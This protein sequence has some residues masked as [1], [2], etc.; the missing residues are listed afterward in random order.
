M[1]AAKQQR[2]RETLLRIEAVALRLFSEQDVRGV[3]VR[4]IVSAA[5]TSTGSF[6][7]RFAS[8]D[9]LVVFLSERVAERGLERWREGLEELSQDLEGSLREATGALA[10]LIVRSLKEERAARTVL[11][12]PG[13]GSDSPWSGRWKEL[14]RRRREDTRRL[15]LAHRA[16]VHHPS[17]ELAASLVYGLAY[18]AAAGMIGEDPVEDTAGLTTERVVDEVARVVH[19]YLGVPH[20][21]VVTQ[22]VALR[23]VD[24]FDVWG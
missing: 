7:A 11:L 9:E 6:Y 13:R 2:S 14:T 16:D 8:K 23:P 24:P 15:I 21:S 12:G 5:R 22:K 18:G 20:E 10:A 3:T 17:P 4:D 1:K 19:T